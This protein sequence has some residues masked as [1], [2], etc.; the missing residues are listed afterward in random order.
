MS[1]FIRCVLCLVAV[2]ACSGSEPGPTDL[3]DGGL[4]APSGVN[5]GGPGP[6]AACSLN[7]NCVRGQICLPRSGA[8][9]NRTFPG[10]CQPARTGCADDEP[11]VCG[12]NGQLYPNECEADGAGVDVG[13]AAQRECIPPSGTFA[14]G[15]RFCRHPAQ[16]CVVDGTQNPYSTGYSCPPV[17]AACAVDRTCACVMRT[18]SCGG[19]IICQE[20]AGRLTVTCMGRG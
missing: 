1:G 2:L 5:G 11:A 19:N 8:C 7:A 12:C 10:M 6:P 16:L 9:G 13:V 3:K 4:D 17:P 20:M 15:F 18:M 14:C